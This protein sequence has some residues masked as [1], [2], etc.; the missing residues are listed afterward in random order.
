MKHTLKKKRNYF[1]IIIISL[2]F[3]IL[4]NI[5]NNKN[6]IFCTKYG[7][8]IFDNLLGFSSDCYERKLKGVIYPN[9]KFNGP[10]YNI[11]KNKTLLSCP[12]NSPIIIITGQSNSANFIMNNKRFKNKHFNY[13]NGKC[14]N[15]SSPVLGSEGE[16]SSL[17]PSIAKKIKSKNKFIFITSGR[18][19]IGIE[20][21][22][23]LDS[24]FINFN[25]EAL[26]RL[27]EQNNYLKYFIWIHGEANNSNRDNYFENFQQ[28]YQKV[29]KNEKKVPFLI[30][31]QTS[32]CKNN[33]DTELNKIQKNIS[34]AFSNFANP[35]QTDD[36]LDDYRYDKCHF[37]QEASSIISDRISALINSYENE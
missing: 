21:V 37:N 19:G 5:I 33:R 8:L 35:I 16:M 3:F 27:H 7:D 11:I 26:N 4:L 13:F 25:L 9:I 31:T 12:K 17:A 18:G 2:I 23:N 22:N 28:M 34:I 24:D 14:Y 36:L 30:I 20:D 1:F 29:I 32:I 6:K 10:R 15:L